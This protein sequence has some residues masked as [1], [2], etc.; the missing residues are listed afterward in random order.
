MN[1]LEIP[2]RLLI[3]IVYARQRY[4]LLISTSIKIQTR[5]E[6]RNDFNYTRKKPILTISKFGV[7]ILCAKKIFYLS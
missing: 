3:T 2:G 7:H 4:Y 1:S 6:I 5:I